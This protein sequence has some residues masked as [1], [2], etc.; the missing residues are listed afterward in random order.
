VYA[1]IVKKAKTNLAVLTMAG[2][3]VEG[4]AHLEVYGSPLILND[5]PE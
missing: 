5:T 4:K 3:T 1:I 2:R